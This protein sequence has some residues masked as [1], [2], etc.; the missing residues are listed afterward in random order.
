MNRASKKLE[1]NKFDDRLE[2]IDPKRSSIKI[3]LWDQKAWLLDQHGKVALVADISTG[4]DGR[5]TGAGSFRVLER[6]E[7]KHSNLYGKLVNKKTGKVEVERSWEHKGAIPKH[8]KYQGTEMLYW[9]RLT[10]SGIGMHIGKFEKR[11]RSSFGCVRVHD[12]AQPLIFEK[13]R[14]GTPV[15]ILERSLVVEMASQQD[16]F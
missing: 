8:L 13:T 3:S 2:Q 6:K 10:W 11:K 12:K 14:L 4:I 9:M 7:S 15:E 5:E 1:F 16:N